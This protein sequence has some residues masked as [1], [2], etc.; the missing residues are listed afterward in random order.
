V[1]AKKTEAESLGLRFVSIP[2]GGWSP[3]TNEQVAQFLFSLPGPIRMKRCSCIACWA[4]IA[5]AFS[6]PPIVWLLKVAGAA[7]AER[8]VFLR[9]QRRFHP[10]MNFLCAGL[11]GAADYRACPGS[12]QKPPVTRPVAIQPN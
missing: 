3:P 1:I 6:W 12:I 8:D 10:A 11:P 5:P 4:R 2:V 7:S 9:F